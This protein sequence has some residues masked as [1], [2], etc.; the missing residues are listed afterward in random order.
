[1]NM[2]IHEY[3]RNDVHVDWLKQKINSHFFIKIILKIALLDEDEWVKFT[4]LKI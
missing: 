4:N 2:N 3:D 1:M